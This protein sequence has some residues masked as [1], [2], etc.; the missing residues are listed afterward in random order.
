MFQKDKGNHTGLRLNYNS[1]L[2]SFE[3]SKMKIC[4]D[5]VLIIELLGFF[6]RSYS[7]ILL[8]RPSTVLHTD[9]ALVEIIQ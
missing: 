4:P 8:L 7:G 9:D 1:N 6:G 2:T 3:Q 5:Y